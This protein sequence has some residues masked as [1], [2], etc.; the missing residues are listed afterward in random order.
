[1]ANTARAVLSVIALHSTR[2]STEILVDMV[3]CTTN[4]SNDRF[5]ASEIIAHDPNST[6]HY[7]IVVAFSGSVG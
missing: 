4:E 5:E 6:K 3:I 7:A 1:M 2:K